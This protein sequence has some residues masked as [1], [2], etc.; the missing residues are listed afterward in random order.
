M[1]SQLV[2]HLILPALTNLTLDI[3][4]REP[5]EDTIS[6][7]LMR[8]NKPALQHLSIAYGAASSTSSFY[9]GPSGVVI[10][11]TS[12]LADLA[13]LRSLHVGGTPLEPLLAALGGPT[14]RRTR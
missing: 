12:L 1:L 14:T 3:E 9:Y 13:H 2:D 10:S 5:I 4:A 6:N 11:W 8:S 7:L